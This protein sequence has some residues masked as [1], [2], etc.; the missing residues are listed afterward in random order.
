M[1]ENITVNNMAIAVV[2]PSYRVTAHILDVISKVGPEVSVIYVV[3]DCCPDGSGKFVETQCI[4]P[5]VEV[6]YNA[7]NL[8]VGG[9]V[10]HGYQQAVSDGVDIIV[11][12][13][14]DGQMDPQL[15]PLFVDPI[16]NG[17]ADY[18]KGNR[19]FNLEEIKSMPTVR[20][21]GNS[22]LSLMTKISSGY[23]DIFDPTNGFTALHV[24]VASNLPL[25]KISSRYFFETDMLY[26][27]NLL[28]A[29]VVDVPM[30][31]VYG[32]EVSNLRISKIVGEFLYKHA[33]NF[34]KRLFYNYCLR[35]VSLASIELPVGIMLM[36]FGIIYGGF[37]W[38]TS[39]RIG[40]PT[41]AGTVMIAALP[42]LTGLQLILSF[43]AY[44]IAT[45]PRRPIH[46]GF[47]I[48]KS[49]KAPK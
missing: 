10:M 34:V 38:V 25:S 21:I 44:D 40:I 30:H 12:V 19:F 48:L 28:K 15:I 32:D 46:L 17:Q 37:H 18:T 6:L 4:D 11:K 49:I 24:Q 27:L 42:I 9:A 26:Q 39:V 5:R 47:R 7:I 45:I 3:D 2:I 22:V 29:V 23:W 33:R 31:A 13:D 14:G 41:T 16:I 1:N 43:L 20:L 8:G 36:L 35:D